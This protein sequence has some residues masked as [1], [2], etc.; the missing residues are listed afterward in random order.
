M[1]LGGMNLCVVEIGLFQ[2]SHCDDN[3]AC[4]VEEVPAQSELVWIT[5]LHAAHKPIIY[6]CNWIIDRSDWNLNQSKC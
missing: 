2:S 5:P 1:N 3:V 4:K 6:H